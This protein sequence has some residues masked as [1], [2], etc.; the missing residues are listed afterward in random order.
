MAGPAV[1][2]LVGFMGISP[3]P[4]REGGRAGGRH[5]R[6]LCAGCRCWRG[7]WR[8][9]TDERTGRSACSRYAPSQG[10]RGSHK[11]LVLGNS[12]VGSAFLKGR[13]RACDRSFELAE[14]SKEQLFELIVESSIDFA[15]FTVDPKGITTSR[16]CGGGAPFPLRG[17]RDALKTGCIFSISGAAKPPPTSGSKP[18]ATWFENGGRQFGPRSKARSSEASVLSCSGVPSNGR[19]MPPASSSPAGATRRCAPNP[20]AAAWPCWPCTSSKGRQAAWRRRA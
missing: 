13:G 4:R 7:L 2:S 8:Q 18:G 14:P 16:K 9:R 1:L 10:T 11:S 5:T 20:C 15:I 6:Q 12:W 19:L 3:R 17:R